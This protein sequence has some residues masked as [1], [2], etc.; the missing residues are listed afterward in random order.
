ME[1]EETALEQP[2]NARKDFIYTVALKRMS[3]RGA[4]EADCRQAAG[5]FRSVAGWKDAD[6]KAEKA[7]EK[8][9]TIRK[10]AIYDAAMEM[11][12]RTPVDENVCLEAAILFQSIS[13]WRGADDRREDAFDK[14]EAERLRKETAEKNRIYA[15][16]EEKLERLSAEILSYEDAEALCREAAELFAGVPGWKNADAE[17]E[18][19]LERAEIEKDARTLLAQGPD[20]LDELQ[21]KIDRLK[22]EKQQLGFFRGSEKQALQERIDKAAEERD[23]LRV[24][25]A[26]LR[27]RVLA[28]AEPGDPVSFGDYAWEDGASGGLRPIEWLALAKEKNRL[29]VVS[30]QA[31]DCVPYHTSQSQVSWEDCSL[32]QWLNGEFFQKAFC[33]GEQEMIP[34]T[35]TD[36]D[37]EPGEG[38]QDRVFLLSSQEAGRYFDS[39]ARRQCAPT[40]FAAGRG[41]YL[42]PENGCCWWWLRSPGGVTSYAASVFPDGSLQG[43]GFEGF[44]SGGGIRPALWIE[45]PPG[46]AGT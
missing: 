8:A 13:G 9:E 25:I 44:G 5:L 19:A 46:P 12:N 27:G 16:A 6:V 29:L 21:K 40:A 17:K 2:E 4:T 22:K 36:P 7:L 35:Q 43:K 45:L 28:L 1:I 24:K 32:R 39:D 10:D 20:R 14:A 23:A 11:L 34:E 37:R 31:L 42:S 33:A 41:C 3:D 18:K 15:E 38:P 26:G 30:R